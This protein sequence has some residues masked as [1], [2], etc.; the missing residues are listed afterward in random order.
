MHYFCVVLEPYW[1]KSKHRLLNDVDI[2]IKT[3]GL[4]IQ[5]VG[6]HICLVLL[7]LCGVAIAVTTIILS[8]MYQSPLYFL[9]YVKRLVE[10]A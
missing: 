1:K 4:T 8:I 9:F 5:L 10:M 7:P 2:T 6:G 3:Y